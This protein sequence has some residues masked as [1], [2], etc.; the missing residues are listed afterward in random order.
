ME[1]VVKLK[2]SFQ[3]PSF[4]MANLISHRKTIYILY[5]RAMM[6]L[7]LLPETTAF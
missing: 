2:I 3:F 1:N 7:S 5:K 6:A 4:L